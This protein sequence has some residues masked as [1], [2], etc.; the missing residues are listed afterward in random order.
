VQ[1]EMDLL[2]QQ[3]AAVEQQLDA[4]K[5]TAAQRKAAE[6]EAEGRLEDAK[7]KLQVTRA[8]NTACV[9]TPQCM[10]LGSTA[11]MCLFKGSHA[12]W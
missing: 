10:Q 9:L 4:A 7:A 1:Q 5:D 3:V 2:Q 11:C 8:A 6:R 12:G